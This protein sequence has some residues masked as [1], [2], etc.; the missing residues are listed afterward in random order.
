MDPMRTHKGAVS[1][2][3]PAREGLAAAVGGQ[4]EHQR[5]P[6]PLFSEFDGC[7]YRLGV[8][9]MDVLII[10]SLPL[11]VC[12]ERLFRLS[13]PLGGP[14]EAQGI[15]LIIRVTYIRPDSEVISRV[16]SACMSTGKAK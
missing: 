5:R 8:L 13:K 6:W 15:L 3:A 1:A 12:F 14:L 9:L 11:E 7:S 2:G 16:R 4:T 10:S